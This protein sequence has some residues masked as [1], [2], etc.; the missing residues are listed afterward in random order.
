MFLCG[1]LQPCWASNSDHQYIDRLVE[2]TK[3]LGLAQQ[4]KWHKLLHYEPGGLISGGM[5]SAILDDDFF[6]HPEGKKDPEKELIATIRAFYSPVSGSADNHVI[7]RFPAR[8]IWLK[9]QLELN[10]TPIT[11]LNCPRFQEWSKGNEIE[12]ISVVYV[13]GY[14]SNPATYYGHILLKFNFNN[15]V[16]VANLLDHSLNYGVIVPESDDPASYIVKSLF[17]GY[18]GGFSLARYHFHTR[19]YG[20]LELRDLWE[21]ELNLSKD[22][23]NF[24]IAHAWEIQ[25]KRY[26][27][28]FFDKNCAYRLAEIFDLVD[29]V[30]FNP[31]NPVYVVPQAVIQKISNSKRN[32]APL[33]RAITYRP[34]RQS[35]FYDRYRRLDSGEKDFLRSALLRP[36]LT[37]AAQFEHLPVASKQKILDTMLDYY[38][39]ALKT[40]ALGK[41]QVER[42]YQKVLA[43]RFD[44]PPSTEMVVR[45]PKDP[46][47]KGRK[48]SRLGVGQI[49]NADQGGMFALEIRPAY[50]DALDGEA[51]HVRH[52]VL[53]MGKAEFLIKDGKLKIRKFNIFNLES[54]NEG[55]T[56]L[57]GDNGKA[58]KISLS[59]SQQNRACFDCLALKFEGDYGW[60]FPALGNVVAGGFIGGRIQDNRIGSGNM[61]VKASMFAQISITPSWNA[62]ISLEAPKQVDGSGGGEALYSI[63]VRKKLD[64]DLDLRFKYH[65]HGTAETIFNVGYYF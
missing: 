34:S 57:P 37:D 25:Q 10:S 63:E 28:Y 56:Q 62:H 20:E 4:S 17:G 61:F 47:H 46:P 29:G 2:K 51:G 40:E 27:Y 16:S 32:G 7:C 23:V 35:R 50:Y 44:L 15:R 19:N 58:W 39:F 41:D 9:R 31:F 38:Q 55:V 13:T 36:E 6:V 60:A 18:D 65:R 8:Y 45:V 52:S 12:S 24:V 1:W 59:G 3:K 48:P 5:R 26:T 22:E 11:T 30:S 49:Y 53:E 42:N 54:V 64:K 33:V 14:L 43:K 21:Y